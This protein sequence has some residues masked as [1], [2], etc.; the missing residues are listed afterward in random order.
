MG[1]PNT[2][3]DV[4]ASPERPEWPSLPGT[5]PEILTTASTIPPAQKAPSIPVSWSTQANKKTAQD[6][7]KDR[8]EKYAQYFK[9]NRI[10]PIPELVEAVQP[11]TLSLI[12]SD[13]KTRRLA[14]LKKEKFEEILKAAGIPAR[15]F[16]RRS[17][18]TWDILLPSQELATKLASNNCINTKQYRL[19]PEYM[20]R[21]RIKVTV[22]N[23]PIQL[24]GDVLA[25]F[26]SDYG[27]VEEYTTMKSP[28]G[29]A[30][31][32]YSFTMCLNRG[33]FQ[34][35]P[36][37]VDYEDQAMLVVVEGR[38]PQC[39][40]CKQV[41]H[42]ARSCPQKT[43]NT[44]ATTTTR[45]TTST[46]SKAT[47][48]ATSAKT[49]LVNN[50]PV[51]SPATAN[52]PE[53]TNT[54]TESGNDPNNKD[55]EG[56]T[57]VTRGKKSPPKAPKS[58][59]AKNTDTEGEKRKPE[60]NTKTDKK[61]KEKA[62]KNASQQEEMDTSSNL[63]RRRDSGDSTTEGE[64]EKK[65]LKKTAQKVQQQRPAQIIP[66][67]QQ[68]KNTPVD[69]TKLPLSPTPP[70]LSPVSTPKILSRSHSA[71]R[72]PTPSPSTS[73]T[74]RRSKSA[75]RE[76]QQALNSF[77][78]CQDILESPS[79]DR[80]IKSLLKPLR[81]FKK[82]DQKEI[83]NPYLFEGA[84]MVT[85]FVRS[86]GGR[87]KELW[88]F[89]EEASRADM[90]LAEMG[91]D[92]L[93]EIAAK[94]TGRVPIYVHPTFYRSLKLRFPYDVGG[95]SR[96]GRVTPELCTGSLRQAVGILTPKDFRPIVDTE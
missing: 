29:T 8:V 17:F 83:T 92:S 25:A 40:H 18:A 73:D 88:Q 41:G 81:D 52:N 36:H 44:T 16:C 74:G 50:T 37:T 42:F 57:Q 30:H 43:T 58:P 27:D 91:H 46:V 32:D 38:K 60:A 87:T 5:S 20:G 82:I 79:L 84:A 69:S 48:V 59:P 77:Y 1:E 67:P 7:K 96:S 21:R 31:G 24:S 12:V 61:K 26:L 94:C 62:N 76:V 54:P 23:V 19:Q 47:I 51:P 13:I 10:L 89:I 56:W 34:A 11:K 71:T 49:P 3:D 75:S 39:W 66:P 14:G 33:G 2:Q 80:Q 93:N 4:F 22:C 35:I 64:G 53:K 85:T 28:N 68:A 9:G 70:T 65:Q 55:E 90:R 15:Y 78:F 86:A 95:I 6:Y 72:N 45:T 63:K